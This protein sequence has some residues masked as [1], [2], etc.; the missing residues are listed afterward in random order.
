VALKHFFE[1]APV[2]GEGVLQQQRESLRRAQDQASS[3]NAA[4][5]QAKPAVT[6]MQSTHDSHMTT[7]QSITP[8]QVPISG[9]TSGPKYGNAQEWNVYGNEDGNLP[10]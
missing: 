9:K 1:E 5:L 8:S 7:P 3:K 10:R 6:P 4:T 2:F